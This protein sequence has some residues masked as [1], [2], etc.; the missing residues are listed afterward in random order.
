MHIADVNKGMLGANDIG[1]LVV[2]G[3]QI[4]T[5]STGDGAVTIARQ[6][7]QNIGDVTVGIGGCATTDVVTGKI[8]SAIASLG[9]AWS[10]KNVRI[11]QAGVGQQLTD[12]VVKLV[13]IGLVDRIMVILFGSLLVPLVILRWRAAAM[14]GTGCRTRGC[15]APAHRCGV[16]TP[17]IW[18]TTPSCCSNPR[19]SRRSQLSTILP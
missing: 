13:V 5:V 18:G 2:A 7:Q 4:A 14:D 12:S 8:S 3:G 1:T 9:K 6:G 17:S 11:G 10:A 16:R 15:L 19:S